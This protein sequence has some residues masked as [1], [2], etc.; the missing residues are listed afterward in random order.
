MWWPRLM[1]IRNLRKE[2]TKVKNNDNKNE[3]KCRRIIFFQITTFSKLFNRNIRS[4]ENIQPFWITHK[5]TVQLWW[6]PIRGDL[7]KYM[8]TYTWAI[9]G[10]LY[11]LF[12]IFTPNMHQI[13]L[14]RYTGCKW[15]YIFGNIS[16]T[17]S[18]SVW[19][20]CLIQ[21][22]ILF[23]CINRFCYICLGIELKSFMI[24]FT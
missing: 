8:G 20:T 11:C 21:L 1:L 10:V 16:V 9:E 12:I 5:P 6:Q 14:S 23:K 18:K 17:R 3:A 22:R 19:S 15:E 24:I 7:T 13:F 2:A 4:H